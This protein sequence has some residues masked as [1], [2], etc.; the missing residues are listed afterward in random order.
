MVCASRPESPGSAATRKTEAAFLPICS[1]LADAEATN[2]FGAVY[3]GPLKAL[4]NDQ[5]G[6]LE[7]LC[8]QLEIPVHRW[9]GDVDASRKARLV[10]QP[11]GI[12][13]I[14]PESLEALFVNRGTRM[15]TM[16]R[17]VRHIV[18]DELHSFIGTE[19]GAQLQSLLHRLELAVRHT[20]PRIGLSATL[21][22]MKSAAEFLRPGGG[23][24]VHIISSSS[25]AQELR[26]QVKGYLDEAPRRGQERAPADEQGENIAGSG[27]RAVADHL[28]TTLRG[29]N[30]NEFVPH[31]GSLSKEI[32]EDTEARLKESSLPMTAICT[33]TLE[34][35]IDIGSIK[36]VA[37]IGAPPGVAAQR[38][39]LGRAGRRGDPAIL[40]M[41][42][43]E[44]EVTSKS[45]PQDELRTQLVQ[46]IAVVN[47]LLGRWY[48]PPEAGGLHL[49]TLVQQILSMI[50]QHG[51]VMPQDAYQVLCVHGP[52]RHVDQ[53]LF[54][55][56]LR[57]L[58]A[59]DLLRQERD[60]LLLHG[61]E[62]ERIA[63]HHTF[64]A[65]FASPEEYRLV[66]GGRTLG[67]LPIGYPLLVG[68]LMIFAGRRWKIVT[69]D[70]RGKV[71]EL[72]PAGGGNA[73]P[74]AG[75]AAD[76][77]DRV[78]SEMRLVYE[79]E[80]M[81]IYLDAGAQQLLTEGRTAYRRL[82][83][84]QTSVVGWGNDTLLVPLRGD[85]IMSTLA[86][87]LHQQDVSVGHEGAVLILSD[88]APRQ[89][90]DLLAA[91]AA[92]PAPEAEELAALVPDKFLEKYDDVLGDELL[93]T[94]YA[95]R[96]LDVPATW[97]ALPDLVAAAERTTPAHHSVQVLTK[98]VR[99]EIGSLPYAVIDVETTGLDALHDRIVEVAVLRLDP[100]G[101]LRR[102]YT[103]VL[104]NDTGPGPTHIHGLTA[105]DLAG[106]PT[107]SDIA[108]DLAE[109]I[110]GAV[111][112]A[113][114]ATF[115]SAMLTTE[116]A[117]TGAAPDDLLVLCTLDLAR[118]FS[119]GQRSLA[120]AY[121]AAEEG[122][123]IAQAHTASHDAQAAA[124]ILLRY[125][126]RAR[127]AGHR[128]LDEVGAIGELPTKQ[129]APWTP[130]R[131][132]QGRTHVPA[133]PLR[134]TLPIPM[135]N[136][137]Q[138]IVYADHVARVAL[139]PETFAAQIPLL[140]DTARKLELDS[141][142]LPRIHRHLVDA[143]RDFPSDQTLLRRLDSL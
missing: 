116:F 119:P 97:A 91:L 103:T 30:N 99:H 122:V 24:K 136:T 21:G 7:E 133:G 18:I 101:T 84:H 72:T 42:V 110:D 70:Q 64:F 115:D 79:T 140:R 16:F 38:Q 98:P 8:E 31:H 139:T 1:A 132:R 96:K 128:W 143:W 61:Q 51:G 106:A 90:L 34:M 32:R 13:L 40:W 126:D 2:G 109:L 14:T 113:H 137:R 48:E 67:S 86:L 6:R 105:G 142:D 44:P 57:D 95:A 75:G 11:S 55:T 17:G 47:L 135:L 49:S 36:S 69:V 27:K 20:I 9:H 93:T 65:A 60:G 41:Y 77:H 22:D 35:G 94:A 66:T 53:Q 25:D 45:R 58:G 129:W 131:R 56:L 62:G 28:F 88:T 39:R 76:V 37:Q 123:S 114:N 43:T 104:Y 83:L 50:S 108:G 102:S 73:P 80:D 15:P 130:S 12:L 124:Q 5:F 89:A 120:L 82:S 52:F 85:T 111:L 46:I 100:D 3:I 33:S 127:Q 112:V 81:P 68:D 125:L 78:R 4:I 59:A 71:I 118:R 54:K 138:E 74:F 134:R 63:N 23:E 26:L 117:R 10:R 121:C 29:S 87:A 19:R 92:G 107:F 141:A